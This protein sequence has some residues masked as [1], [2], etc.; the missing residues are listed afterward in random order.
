MT[1]QKTLTRTCIAC[2]IEKPLSAF[3]QITGAQ[4]TTYG[5]ICSRCRSLGIKEKT[6]ILTPDDERGSTSS[7]MRIGAKQRFEIDQKRQQEYQEAQNKQELESKKREK[8]VGDQSERLDEKEKAEKTHRENYIEEKKKG[9]LNY[10]SKKLPL[11][12]QYIGLKKDEPTQSNILPVQEEK[13]TTVEALKQEPNTLSNVTISEQ[14]S[15]SKMQTW[16][17]NTPIAKDIS[18][19]YRNAAQTKQLQEKKNLLLKTT[20]IQAKQIQEKQN[21]VINQNKQTQEKLNYLQNT[22]TQNRLT[23][24]KRNREKLLEKDPREFIEKTWGPSSRKR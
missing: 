7:G 4:G 3:L 22:T 14:N 2:G 15:L 9:F 13:P 1:K 21:T 23:Q 8:M 6:S 24:E 11:S 16:L 5:N 20:T 12:G 10:Q 17:G 19:L 18:Q